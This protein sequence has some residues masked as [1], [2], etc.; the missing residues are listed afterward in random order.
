MWR[1]GYKESWAA[2]NWCFWA[3]VLEK[4]LESPLDSKEIQ[5]V[6]SKG[7]HSWIYI[8]RTDAE[9][10]TP[11]LWPPDTKK[12]LIEKDPDSGKDWRE[13]KVTTENEMVGCITNLMDMSLSKLWDVVMDREAWHAA[14]RG[15][16]MNQTQL[17]D[18]TELRYIPSEPSNILDTPSKPGTKLGT[19]ILKMLCLMSGRSFCLWIAF[20]LI[21]RHLQNYFPLSALSLDGKGKLGTLFCLAWL[22]TGVPVSFLIYLALSK[23]PL[24]KS[25]WLNVWNATHQ[26][27][28]DW[29]LKS[30][31]FR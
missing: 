25:E 20:V 19:R 27:N 28:L 24:A 22:T 8:G 13:E 21:R 14:V 9:A 29:T 16:A 23:F 4:T 2:K 11:I 18:W 17:S 15:V 12:W 7:N 3:L 1:L 5:P 31:W 30:L 10:K 26:Q 6:H